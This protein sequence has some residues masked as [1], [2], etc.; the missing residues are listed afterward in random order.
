MFL[1]VYPAMVVEGSWSLSR[2][3]VQPGQVVALLQSLASCSLKHFSEEI[4]CFVVHLNHALVTAPVLIQGILWENSNSTS[5]NS[6]CVLNM[7][8]LGI[9]CEAVIMW[10]LS[11]I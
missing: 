9:F 3:L 1:T 4:C 6:G 5:K 11:V 7:F 8:H 2:G 10:P